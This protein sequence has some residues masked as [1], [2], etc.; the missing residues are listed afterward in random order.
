MD[1]YDPDRRAGWSV[2]VRGIATVVDD[3]AE[4]ARLSRIGVWPAAD[5]VARHYT[6]RILPDK[7]TGR[8]NLHP[9]AAA[10]FG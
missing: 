7:I 5:A 10:I 4:L 2:V 1:G 8:Q 9:A 3:P 6:V